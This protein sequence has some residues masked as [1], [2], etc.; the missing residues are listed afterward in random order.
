MELYE[1]TKEDVEIQYDQFVALP[2][3]DSKAVR[4]I[5][6]RGGVMRYLLAFDGVRC[7]N[8]LCDG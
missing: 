4:V 2:K 3:A 1:T 6:K 8:E 7:F 5:M